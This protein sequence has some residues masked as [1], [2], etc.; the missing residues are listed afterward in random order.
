MAA[1]ADKSINEMSGKWQLERKL[2]TGM[3]EVMSLQGLSWMKIKALSMISVT[4]TCKQY[5][6]DQN[7]TH[8]DIAPTVTGGFKGH[9]S[10]HIV[11]GMER[12][13]EVPEFGTVFETCR[14]TDLSNVD[15][16]FL[17]DG[18]IYGDGEVGGLKNLELSATME[19]GSCMF[20]GVWGFVEVDGKRY[21]ARKT[22]CT[23]GGKTEKC[24]AIYSWKE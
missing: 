7:V 17:R 1:P 9:D 5:V 19:K 13:V 15:D 2:S 8:I 18:W 10:S 12:S 16:D 11:D 20:K 24:C 14:W 6:D 22:T 4:E 23:K 3:D 21:H